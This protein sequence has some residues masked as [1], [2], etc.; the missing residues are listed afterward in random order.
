MPRF[1]SRIF[2]S[3]VQSNKT[4]SWKTTPMLRIAKV[5]SIQLNLSI[6]IMY[7]LC[8]KVV[9][10]PNWLDYILCSNI[11]LRLH[12]LLYKVGHS[13]L[14]TVETPTHPHIPPLGNPIHHHLCA[15]IE[16]LYKLIT[17]DF[18]PINQNNA[19]VKMIHLF[20][21]MV[22]AVLYSFQHVFWW[23]WHILIKYYQNMY[24]V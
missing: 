14:S 13:R 21:N 6:G 11:P 7:A 19:L 1:P 2:S 24:L 4:G 16:S 3:I 12:T 15:S 20:G 23:W 10:S 5:S 17:V 22:K 8:N 18:Q 9:V